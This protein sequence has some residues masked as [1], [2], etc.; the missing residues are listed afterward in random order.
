[1]QFLIRNKLTLLTFIIGLFTTFITAYKLDQEK[2]EQIEATLL[3]QAD[4]IE[5]EIKQSV[6]EL[7]FIYRWLGD[8]W[9]ING[10]PDRQ[11]RKKQIEKILLNH[12]HVSAIQWISKDYILEWSEPENEFNSHL[13]IDLKSFPSLFEE[14]EFAKS[15]G[16]AVTQLLPHDGKN[17]QMFTIYFPLGINE[18]NAGFISN[19]IHIDNYFRNIVRLSID[20]GYQVS[21]QA[22]GMDILTFYGDNFVNYRDVATI[23]TGFLG[24]TITIRVW[25][26]PE[27]LAH[28][29]K[30]FAN[31]VLIF[32]SLTTV[33]VTFIT[34]LLVKSIYQEK[35]L[36]K[37][38]IALATQ[39][40]ERAKAEHNLAQLVEFDKL[41][42]LHNRQ[43]LERYLAKLLEDKP[44]DKHALAIFDLDGFKEV[45]GVLG[46]NNGDS[47]IKR[48]AQ[49]IQRIIPDS[50]YIARTGGDEFAIV[51]PQIDDVEEVSRL[52][53][54][55]IRAIDSRFVLDGYELYLSG[56]AGLVIS[57]KDNN[58]FINLY[59]SADTALN[60]AK[61]TGKNKLTVYTPELQIDTAERVELLKR[62]R[63]A[64][65]RQ[66]FVLYFQPKV[67]IRNGKCTGAEA[68]IR[69]V[70]EELGMIPPN[71]FIPIA[72]D[73]GLIIQIGEWVIEKSCQQ[74]AYWHKL[75]FRELSVSINLSGKQL[76]QANLIDLV[77]SNQERYKLPTNKIELELT[78]QVFIENIDLSTEFMH[79]IRD[80]GF[81]LSIDDFGVGYSSL[82]YLKHFPVDTLKID[83]SFIKNLPDDAD[84]A[85]LAQTIVNLAQNMNL[86]VV[87][88]GVEEI[89]QLNYLASQGC[90][91][92]QGYLFS[93]PVSSES[94]TKFL[95][96]QHGHFSAHDEKPSKQA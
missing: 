65:A 72:E 12:K 43:A 22:N 5:R 47:L 50:G 42:G 89:Q 34:H 32:G 3:I 87:A 35:K 21:I 63:K 59:R 2:H 4:K 44:N 54:K 91:I 6:S 96:N 88:E 20:D 60:K 74:L 94:F 57:D 16:Q 83:R 40:E 77:I 80:R 73:S 27:N 15:T 82:S 46:H 41:T 39:V 95:I 13:G 75:G 33:L 18:D 31:Y 93:K 53:M 58:N 7:I 85:I 14:L 11:L 71:E 92:V 37:T 23:S 66:E 19:V 8:Q 67:D 90:F 70:D 17:D 62:L 51:L 48:V 81:S 76:Q 38:N 68:L 61:E 45:N 52:L 30:S 78:E 26:T 29:G 56:S 55:I 10:Q 79:Q 28:L 36:Y 69:W 1:M 49:R 64:I 86:K 84:D 24:G 25:P 9:L